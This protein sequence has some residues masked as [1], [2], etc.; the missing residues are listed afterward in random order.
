MSEPPAFRRLPAR[1]FVDHEATQ[2]AAHSGNFV[3]LG[4]GNR[5]EES[6]GGVER[7]LG[8]VAGELLLVRPLVAPFQKLADQRSLSGDQGSAGT[9]R[10]TNRP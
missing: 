5:G 9:R 8:V 1:L 6:G 2:F 3:G 4:G 7:A 10:P